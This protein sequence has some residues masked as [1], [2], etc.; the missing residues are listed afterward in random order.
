MNHPVYFQLHL[1]M[2]VQMINPLLYSL[3]LIP[4]ESYG[5]IKSS[6][7]SNSKSHFAHHKMDFASI[8]S[9][10]QNCILKINYK[11]H[12]AKVCSLY[13]YIIVHSIAYDLSSLL[14]KFILIQYQKLIFMIYQFPYRLDYQNILNSAKD[15]ID[16]NILVYLDWFGM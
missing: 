16:K 7:Y 15:C 3:Q 13:I 5:W 9:L 11:Q 10:R 6:N 14:G 2:H 1:K 4:L 8:P 12:L